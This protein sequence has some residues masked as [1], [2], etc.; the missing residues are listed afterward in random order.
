M[1][2]TFEGK[3]RH[4]GCE[5]LNMSWWQKGKPKGPQSPELIMKRANA[6]RGSKR[7][8]ES[9]KIQSEIAL[10]SFRNGRITHNKGKTKSNYAPLNSVS[11]KMIGNKNSA[12]YRGALNPMFGKSAPHLV[13]ISKS[14]IGI[15]LPLE[16][17]KKMSI[18]SKASWVKTREKRIELLKKV[19]ASI[20][21]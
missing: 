8:K 3:L 5:R 18:K 10:A 6:I 21:A 14:R 12:C 13:A 9:K 7:S 1:I 17:R 20:S 19:W 15:P 4:T 2:R 16:Q 11:T